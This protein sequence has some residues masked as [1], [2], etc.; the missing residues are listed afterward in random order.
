MSDQKKAEEQKPIQDET[1]DKVSGGYMINH[2]PVSGPH[3]PG[4]GGGEKRRPG[5]NEPP[6]GEPC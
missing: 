6:H 3:F 2:N 1:L 5:S 4:G